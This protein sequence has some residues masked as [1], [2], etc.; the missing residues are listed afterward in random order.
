MDSKLGT[1]GA[2]RQ[3]RTRRERDNL[4]LCSAMKTCVVTSAN[5]NFF[6]YLEDLVRS[7]RDRPQ[8][9][10]VDLC[11]LDVGLS[12]ENRSWLAP[13]AASIVGPGW[14][15]RRSSDEKAPEHEKSL[16]SR[17]FLPEHFPG[18]DVYVHIDADAWVQDWSAIDLLVQAASTGALAIVPEVDRAYPAFDTKL[19]VERIMGVPYRISSGGWRRYKDI[20]GRQV[21]DRLID[22]PTLN[23]GVFALAANAPHWQAWR[24][25][26]Q[27]A[28]ERS[29]RSGLDQLTLEYLTYG[30][31][32][33]VELLPATCN[34]VAHRSIPKYDVTR[35][36]LVEPY[37]PHRDIGILHLTLGSKDEE[38]EIQTLDGK[39]ITSTLRYSGAWRTHSA[40]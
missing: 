20:Y 12:E 18:Y 36:R 5:A 3:E 30:L 28:L 22:Q 11:V 38:R 40:D 2:A 37:L 19:K 31:R 15:L 35:N 32:M 33:P 6:P 13:L 7:I 25:Q 1:P 9:N 10:A 8:S 21:A 4:P 26:F 23:A 29:R 16:R 24:E 39:T 14:D 17:P 34:W 27:L